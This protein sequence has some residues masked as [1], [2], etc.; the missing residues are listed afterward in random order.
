MNFTPRLTTVGDAGVSIRVW[1]ASLKMAFT[2]GVA[3]DFDRG[4]FDL[5]ISPGF[6]TSVKP[7]KQESNFALSPPASRKHRKQF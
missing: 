2:I 4:A 7:T 1:V 5:S 3:W 6:G